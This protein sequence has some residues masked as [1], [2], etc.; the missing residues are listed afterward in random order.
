[1]LAGLERPTSGEIFL[2]ETLAMP[3][4]GGAQKDRFCFQ[5]LENFI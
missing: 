5:H 3:Y 1:M 2:E 4:R